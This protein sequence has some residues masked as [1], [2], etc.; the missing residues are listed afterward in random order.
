MQATKSHLLKYSIGPTI[1]SLYQHRSQRE[2]NFRYADLGSHFLSTA[3]STVKHNLQFPSQTTRQGLGD[4]RYIKPCT[5]AEQRTLITRALHNESAY[6]LLSHSHTLALQG[7]WTHW[8]TTVA[9][10]DLSWRNILYNISPTLLSFVLNA[11]I[12]STPSPDMLRLWGYRINSSCYLCNNSPCTLHH[13]LV[14]CPVS[15]NG[16]RYNWRHDSVLLTLQPYLLPQLSIYN[17]RTPSDNMSRQTTTFVRP[18]D[19][20]PPPKPK[21]RVTQL[22]YANDW[23]ILIDYQHAPILFPLELLRQARDP[24]SSFGQLTRHVLY[25]SN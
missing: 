4:G 3:E 6:K 2:S 10:F 7:V 8:I 14:N 9:P 18:G 24:T 11:M 5:Y 23:R 12:N 16:S 19:R 1:R 21:H 13:I 20:P 17:S 25:Y 22:S 15:L